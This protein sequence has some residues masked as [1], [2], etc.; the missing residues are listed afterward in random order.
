RGGPPCLACGARG[1][2]GLLLVV[3]QRE[4]E[5]EADGLVAHAPIV[6]GDLPARRRDRVAHDGRRPAGEHEAPV[7]VA[8]D[9]AELLRD[10]PGPPAHPLAQR[11]LGVAEA[12]DSASPWLR[13]LIPRSMLIGHLTNRSK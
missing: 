5:L 12:A 9:E 8:V 2:D 4:G 10:R 13:G 6:E 7:G 1:K 11:V 3:T